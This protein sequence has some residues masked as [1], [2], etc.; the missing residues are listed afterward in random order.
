MATRLNFIENFFIQREKIYFYITA[1]L[2][3][4]ELY[5]NLNWKTC[6]AVV[7]AVILLIGIN[8]QVCASDY[9]AIDLNPNGS[10][11][12]YAYGASGGQQ[13]GIG[14]PTG[15]VYH[16]LLWSG[17]A[18]SAVDLNP[19]GFDQ[20]YAYGISGGQQVGN[21]HSFSATGGNV[22]AM[23]WSGT[24][25][26]AV[27][28]NPSGF[29]SSVANA[30]S[31]GQQVGGG[32]GAATGGNYI[33]HALLWSGSA[34]SAVDLNPSGFD[35]SCALGISGG[36]QVGYGNGS[37]TSGND[38]ALI[39][40]GSADSAIDL[41]QFLPSRWSNSYAEAVDAQGNIVG[42]AMDDTFTYHA[43]LWQP[44]PEPGTFVML[45]MGAISFGV[46]WRR[47]ER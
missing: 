44:V 30:T 38:H 3:S 29:D 43:I 25:A 11:I 9:V 45:G 41:S 31:N 16:A 8:K 23:L 20:S 13:V 27:D 24:A 19:S 18:A 32:W 40:S 15:P 22:H 4:E 2:K 17:S 5:M 6:L 37:A 39:W 21:G 10:N 14:N 12:C 28:L 35:T 46:F 7:S 1:T 42:Y 26:S 33:S 34:A 36:Q 47:R